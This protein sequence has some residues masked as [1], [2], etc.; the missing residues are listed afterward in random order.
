MSEWH[1]VEI[2]SCPLL[3]CSN[4]SCGAWIS[5]EAQQCPAC[6]TLQHGFRLDSRF[7]IETLLGHGGD[8]DCLSRH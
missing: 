8:G 2:P 7:R 5:G 6:G 4:P 1:P 3:H